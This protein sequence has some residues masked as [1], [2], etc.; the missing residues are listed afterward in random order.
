V[1]ATSTIA[2]GNELQSPAFKVIGA[3]LAVQVVVH[4]LYVSVNTLW[5]AVDGTLFN[6]PELAGMNPDGND[7]RRRRSPSPPR[8][9]TRW[10]GHEKIGDVEAA[11]GENG[12]GNGHGAVH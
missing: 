11:T 4:W 6:A 7:V 12:N 8:V 3:F 2:L 1:F 10:V 5:K 9:R